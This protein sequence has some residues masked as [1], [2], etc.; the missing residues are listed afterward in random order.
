MYNI[1]YQKL[2][3]VFLTLDDVVHECDG[4][5]AAILSSNELED[6]LVRSIG[7]LHLR[8]AGLVSRQ[9]FD[10]QNA[11]FFNDFLKGSCISKTCL[12]LT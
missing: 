1:T 7:A 11:T 3:N 4:V 9:D 12:S 5:F 2:V 8:S 6:G 10:L